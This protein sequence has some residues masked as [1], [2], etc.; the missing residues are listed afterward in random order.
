MEMFYISDL[1]FLY[2]YLQI[3][4]TALNFSAL[5]LG[6]F[7]VLKILGKIGQRCISDILKNFL[8][9][10]PRVTPGITH[11]WVILVVLHLLGHAFA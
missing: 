3:F 1:R 7:S 5:Y 11:P 9:L 6:N 4:T 10:C 2:G 8:A